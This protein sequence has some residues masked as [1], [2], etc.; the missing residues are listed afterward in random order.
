MTVTKYKALTAIKEV[1]IVILLI[2][3]LFV[4]SVDPAI[5]HHITLCQKMF[6]RILNFLTLLHTQDL[7]DQ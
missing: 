6:N 4:V 3:G 5:I 1:T 7:K 2:G